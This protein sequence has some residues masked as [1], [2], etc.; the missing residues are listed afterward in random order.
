[1]NIFVISPQ[2]PYPPTTGGKKA[3]YDVL[4]LLQADGHRIHVACLID[5]D[6]LAE[7]QELATLMPVDAVAMT[8]RPT[9]R[10]ACASLMRTM[11]YQL[12]RFTNTELLERCRLI[13]SSGQFDIIQIE[14]IHAAWYGLHLG[15][16][17]HLPVA[18]RVYDVL[19]M[20]MTRSIRHQS[21]W[22]MKLW[23]AFDAY[24]VRM[25]EADVYGQVAMNLAVSDHDKRLIESIRPGAR[26]HVVPCGTD[27]FEYAPTDIQEDPRSILW[28]GAFSHAPNRD[29]FWWFYREILPRI[30]VKNNQICVTVVGTA[31]PEEIQVLQHPNVRVVGF[32]PDVR[33]VMAQACVCVVPIRFGSGVRIK[34][35]EMFAMRKAVVAT[36][37]GAEGL[38]VRSGEHLLVG[39]SA[40]RF[41]ESVIALLADAPERSRLGNNAYEHISRHFSLKAAVRELEA[42]YQTILEHQR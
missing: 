17:F 37:V 36:S 3:I 22:L 35:L 10:G 14:G 13:L 24:R 8:K 5:H 6:E 21:N 38:A 19:S 28:I 23:L 26:C 40:E 41:A 11:P 33:P 31:M 42:V 4:R 39:D 29:S 32:V 15:R 12:S 27:F 30:L 34:L 18:M 20:M 2:L 16:E 25:Y 9:L 1:M 7:A